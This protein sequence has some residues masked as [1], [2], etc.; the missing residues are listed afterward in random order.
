MI[1]ISDIQVM[2]V[3]D[4]YLLIYCFKKYPK[5]IRQQT[6]RELKK[7]VGKFKILSYHLKRQP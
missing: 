6:I 7:Q 1:D 3:R 5:L 4:F 2:Y